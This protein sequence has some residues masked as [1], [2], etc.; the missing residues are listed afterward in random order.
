MVEKDAEMRMK[1]AKIGKQ[2]VQLHEMRTEYLGRLRNACAHERE[3]NDENNL[4]Q[5][6]SHD[7]AIKEKNAAIKLRDATIQEKEAAVKEYHGPFN[8]ANQEQKNAHALLKQLIAGQ[9]K[10]IEQEKAAQD[11]GTKE[12]IAECNKIIEA[13]TATH[14]ASILRLRHRYAGAEVALAA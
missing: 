9:V 8:T 4:R 14:K 6:L 2:K 10:T 13:D 5:K 1:N 12:V 7:H 11:A 3:L